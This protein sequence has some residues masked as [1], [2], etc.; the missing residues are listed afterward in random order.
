[1][2]KQRNAD[3]LPEAKRRDLT[4]AL[5]AP[6]FHERG[7]VSIVLER[8]LPLECAQLARKSL[9]QLV[10]KMMVFNHTEHYS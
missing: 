8:L 10:L 9:F 6:F 1:M 3:R 2:E 7:A 5:L 4:D